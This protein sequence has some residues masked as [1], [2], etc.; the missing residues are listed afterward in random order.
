MINNKIQ[1]IDS[2]LKIEVPTPYEVPLTLNSLYSIGVNEEYKKNIKILIDKF[3]NVLLYELK[4]PKQIV[5]TYFNN[6]TIFGIGVDN[7]H[8]LELHFNISSFFAQTLIFF[9]K[10]SGDNSNPQPIFEQI[11]YYELE[12][13]KFFEVVK[14]ELNQK[15]I[16][17]NEM[18]NKTFGFFNVDI[19]TKY[20]S[21]FTKNYFESEEYCNIARDYTMT[22]A[23]KIER[24]KQD[25]NNQITHCIRGCR[26]L[27]E[28]YS[29]FKLPIS[30]NADIEGL[31]LLIYWNTLRKI[32]S[33][34]IQNNLIYSVINYYQKNVNNDN[35]KYKKINF[36]GKI[37]TFQDFEKLIQEYL[38]KHKEINMER[39]E[40]GFFDQWSP[41]E[42]NEYLNE[43]EKETLKKF[44]I[45]NPNQIFFP[46]NR[47]VDNELVIIDHHNTIQNKNSESLLA[48]QKRQFYADHNDKIYKCLMG[49]D[50]FKGHIAIVLNNGYVI[51]EKYDIKDQEFSTKNGAAYI[52]TIN[53]FNKFSKKSLTEVRDYIKKQNNE[54]VQMDQ[55]TFK[56]HKGNWKDYIEKYFNLDTNIQLENINNAIDFATEN[57]TRR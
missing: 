36:K 32:N 24:I 23:Q 25:L 52:M 47:V 39:I 43:F 15:R 26:I 44:E 16:L 53:N 27:N 5:D 45:I 56:C 34:N 17:I 1:K 41:E 29:K 20:P 11:P 55:I 14:K 7:N 37:Y 57:K 12:P 33:T 18:N 22:D 49:K 2:S 13:K 38:L 40:D 8:N 50:E 35:L 51:F 48:L 19:F 4:F 21:I 6:G 42:I 10:Y 54:I 31:K 9:D 46:V 3:E 28:E 30:S